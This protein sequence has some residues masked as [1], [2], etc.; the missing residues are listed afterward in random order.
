MHELILNRADRVPSK[1]SDWASPVWRDAPLAFSW[2][3][4]QKGHP[5]RLLG[6]PR[7]LAFDL[8]DQSI[9]LAGDLGQVLFRP[10]AKYG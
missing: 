3:C 8:A 5:K 9:E 7:T 2:G 6:G 4:F 1:R 10:T